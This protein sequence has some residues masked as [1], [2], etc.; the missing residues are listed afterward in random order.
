[1]PHLFPPPVPGPDSNPDPNPNLKLDLEESDPTP[2]TTDSDHLSLADLLTYCATDVHTAHK[3]YSTILPSVSTPRLLL[4]R[5]RHGVWLSHSQQ[6]L[7]EV[8]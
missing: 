8:Y 3:V 5:T 2:P 1:M 6:R 7:G 4:R